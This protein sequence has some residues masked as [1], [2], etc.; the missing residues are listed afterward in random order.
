[1]R[2]V[3]P[4]LF[5]LESVTAAECKALGL[6]NGMPLVRDGRVLVDVGPLGQCGLP[7]ARANLFLRTAERVLLEGDEFP[8]PDFD[9]LFDRTAAIPWELLLPDGVVVH[10]RGS[11]RTSRLSSVPA[12]QSIVR[13]AVAKRL[14]AGGRARDPETGLVLEDPARGT[15]RISFHLADDRAS[16]CLDTSGEPLHKRGIRPESV[17]APLR[18]TLAAGLVLLSRWQPDTGEALVDPFCG[19]GTLLV[20]A[21]RMALGIAP[22]I[23]RG[24]FG[25]TLP[26]VGTAFADARR[27]AEREAARQEDRLRALGLEG[28]LPLFGSDVDPDA[29]RAT[30]DNAARAGVPGRIRLRQADARVLTPAGLMKDTG[31]DSLL[32]L[33]NPPYGERLLDRAAARSLYEAL[34]RSFLQGGRPPPGVRMGILAPADGFEDAVG[35]AA[36]RRRKLYNGMIQ[37][38]LYQFQG[39]GHP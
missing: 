37:C 4:V 2:L 9:A 26:F 18:E 8:A 19:S 14:A 28:P 35:A 20:E 5:G 16:L 13:K 7:V 24:F 30:R 25:E 10:V 36:F 33:T 34:G 12:C 27:E 1:M 3:L 21:A 11:S 15:A 17:D 39:R 38:Y 22:G 23:G 31:T 6:G 29:L 32:I